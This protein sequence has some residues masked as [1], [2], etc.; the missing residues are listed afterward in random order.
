MKQNFKSFLGIDPSYHEVYELYCIAEPTCETSALFTKQQDRNT[1]NV[2]IT[3]LAGEQLLLT[4]KSAMAL[5]RWLQDEH[6]AGVDAETYY[7]MKQA[8]EKDE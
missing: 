2:I 8:A 4:P 5:R 3:S 6:M 7:A 1:P